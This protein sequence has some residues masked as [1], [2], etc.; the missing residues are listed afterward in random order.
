MFVIAR[1]K[2]SQRGGIDLCGHF[3]WYI[4]MLS[5]DTSSSQY[6]TN[7]FSMARLIDAGF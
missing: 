3:S 6:L 2:S 5:L 7:L 1:T 4:E